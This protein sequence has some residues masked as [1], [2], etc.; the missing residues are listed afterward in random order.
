MLA[1]MGIR[2][3]NLN[4]KYM[5]GGREHNRV[6]L[7]Q[8]IKK[9]STASSLLIVKTYNACCFVVVFLKKDGITSSLSGF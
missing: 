8:R 9:R 7:L 1:T 5:G 3:K 2:L 4:V 6:R